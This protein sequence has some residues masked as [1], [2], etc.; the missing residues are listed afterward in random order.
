MS[1]GHLNE[2]STEAASFLYKNTKVSCIDMPHNIYSQT[3][4]KRICL[5]QK[6]RELVALKKT[7]NW[8]TS[9]LKKQK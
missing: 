2:S 7:V 3:M 9:V 6:L 8:M 5:G 4:Q 1:G